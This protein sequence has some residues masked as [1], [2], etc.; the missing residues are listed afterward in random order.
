MNEFQILLCPYSRTSVESSENLNYHSKSFLWNFVLWIEFCRIPIWS[1]LV[2]YFS[3][4]WSCLTCID[5]TG[6]SQITSSEVRIERHDIRQVNC[7]NPLLL[8]IITGEI[9]YVRWEDTEWGTRKLPFFAMP[10]TMYNEDN[11]H[12]N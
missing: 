7:R 5:T 11:L 4:F 12:R 2:I 10:M 3:F 1:F 6:K 9:T 8:N